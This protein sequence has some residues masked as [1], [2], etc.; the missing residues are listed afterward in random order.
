MG[1][2][3]E[4]KPPACTT[5]ARPRVLLLCSPCMG[6]LIPFAELAR[7]L[8]AD[9]GLSTTLLFASATSPPSEQYLAVAAAVPD[10]VDLVALPAPPP[11]ALPPATAARERAELAVASNVPR[12]REIARE[13]GA[14]APLVALVVDMVGAAAAAAARDVAAELGVPFYAFFT[15]PW[16][17]LSLLLRLPE[18]DAARAG[19]HRDA[20][21][22]IRLPGC[23]PIHA[24]ELPTS[25]LADRSSSAYAGFLSMAKGVAGVDGVLV[26]TFGELEPAVGGDGRLQLPVYPVGPLVWTRPAGVDTDHECMSWLDGQPRGSVAYVSFGSGGTITWQQTAELALG[27]ELSQCRF[28]WAIKRPH[29]SSTIA[30]FFGTQRGDE[31][32]PLDFL[33]EGFME[34]TRG[35]GLVTQSWAPQTAILGHPSIGCFVTHC[36]WNSVLESVIN[37]VPMVAWPLYAEQN[38]N[39]AMMEVQVGVA[40]RAKVGADRFI[41]KDEVANAIRRAIVGEEAERLRKRSSEL[42]RQSA[43]ALSKDGCSTRALAQIANAWKCASRK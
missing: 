3:Q 1:K 24:H 13:L 18:I 25:M 21:E 33:P 23:V 26:N 27:L 41:W 39:A 8:V 6:H 29:Q 16:M 17:T 5:A 20:A 32:S 34:R 22:P 14:A 40:L 2:L 36:G 10:D 7:R 37:G 11:D 38:M 4:R 12:V 35:V 9:H 31:H 15:S 43:Q 30:A 19:E 28:I 42:R